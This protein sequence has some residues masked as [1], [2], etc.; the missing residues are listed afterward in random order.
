MARYDYRC[1]EHGS[2]EVNKPM[3]DA[4]RVETC[5]VCGVTAARVFAVPPVHYH[6][7]GFHATDYFKGNGRAGTKADLL[8]KDYEKQYGEPAPPPA[9]DVPR[10]SSDK[11]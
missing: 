7:D 2:F 10:N 8:R 5:P 1:D 11:V 6:T 3:S 4:G 9:P